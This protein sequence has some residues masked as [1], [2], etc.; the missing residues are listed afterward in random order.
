[1]L[2][3]YLCDLLDFNS[4]SSIWNK[5][6]IVDFTHSIVLGLDMSISISVD[7]F[8]FS[9]TIITSVHTVWS[10]KDQTITV[11]C[12]RVRIW[13]KRNN[14]KHPS[15]SLTTVQPTGGCFMIWIIVSW[16]TLE[17]S[18]AIIVRF[19]A[20]GYQCNVAQFMTIWK[21]I[22]FWSV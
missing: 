4:Y 22:L 1:M 10:E 20:A 11:G 9:P 3:Y 16:H 19:N 13:L 7:L 12:G 17:S 14:S 6:Y 5:D 21:H 2:L 8:R 18:V 15:F